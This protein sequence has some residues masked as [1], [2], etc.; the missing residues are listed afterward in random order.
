MQVMRWCLLAA[1]V[2]SHTDKIIKNGLGVF[3]R[4]ENLLLN[5]NNNFAFS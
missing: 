2:A 5:G 4:E 1:A 3:E